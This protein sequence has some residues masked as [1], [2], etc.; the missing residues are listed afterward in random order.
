MHFREQ[1]DN[2]QVILRKKEACC[3]DRQSQEL[4]WATLGQASL[5]QAAWYFSY[6]SASLY[7]AISLAPRS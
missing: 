5:T 4:G 2:S 6:V 1:N 3:K 7:V